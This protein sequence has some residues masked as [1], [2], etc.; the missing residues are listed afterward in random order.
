V[1]LT[2]TMLL[3]GLWHGASIKFVL[4]GALHGSG[5]AIERWAADASGGRRALKPLWAR[6]LATVVVFHFVCFCWI[7]FR[8]KDLAQAGEVIAGLVDWSQP[9]QLVTPFMLVLLA[10]GL[11]VQFTP[12]DLLVRL[13]HLYQSLPVWGVGALSGAALLLIELLGGD[14]TAPF[15]YFQF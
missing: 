3:G 5:L 12:R 9:A 14:S 4:W 8:A 15:I 2:I 11:A 1:N 7:F 10:I 6:A 13:D